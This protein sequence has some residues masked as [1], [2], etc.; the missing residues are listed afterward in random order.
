VR[1]L[2]IVRGPEAQIVMDF[3]RELLAAGTGRS[4]E[5]ALHQIFLAASAGRTPA[6][7]RVD[8]YK[9]LVDGTEIERYL[10]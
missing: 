5:D 8:G 7:G 1:V 6:A 3:S 10:P 9:V 2:S 4:L